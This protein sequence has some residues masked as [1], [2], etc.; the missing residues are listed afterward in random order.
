MF[1]FTA[2]ILWFQNIY[3]PLQ[4]YCSTEHGLSKGKIDKHVPFPWYTRNILKKYLSTE[5]NNVNLNGNE[6]QNHHYIWQN[7]WKNVQHFQN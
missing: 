1:L 4:L 2:I 6:T 5:E 3:N 7:F